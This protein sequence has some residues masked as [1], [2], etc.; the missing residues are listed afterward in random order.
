MQQTKN[1]NIEAACSID[2][3]IRCPD[4]R[5]FARVRLAARAAHLRRIGKHRSV[6]QNVSS[7]ALGSSKISFGYVID[8]LIEISSRNGSPSNGH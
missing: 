4:D 6:T 3:D 5:K 2:D 1:F 8:L 7:Q